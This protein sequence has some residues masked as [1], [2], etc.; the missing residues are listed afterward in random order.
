MRDRITDPQ[1]GECVGLA[2]GAGH[3]QVG[4]AR[5]QRQGRCVVGRIDEFGIGLVHHH[6]HPLRHARQ[7]VGEGL[8][9]EPGTGRVVG[10]G[11]VHQ[12]GTRADRFQQ[13][14][15]VVATR[16]R[17]LARQRRRQPQFRTDRL[18]CQR[19]H[20]ETEFRGDHLVAGP[21]EHL[22]K[23]HQQFMRAIAQHQVARSNA[24]MA[25]QRALQIAAKR[26]RIDMDAGKSIDHR[27]LRART[28]PVRV[29]VGAQLQ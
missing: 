8:R 12:L 5:D 16:H 23:L 4:M 14:G 26:I 21:G 7:E 11:Q 28:G 27:L 13:R 10:V 1:A 25:G 17:M 9:A 22:R 3:H 18:R 24:V 20:R 19:I 29:L 15:Q 2:E 6:D